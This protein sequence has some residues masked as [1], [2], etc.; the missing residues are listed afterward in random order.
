VFAAHLRVDRFDFRLRLR[1]RD[2]RR[3]ASDNPETPGVTRFHLVI[4]E[5]EWLP[6]FRAPAE[7]AATAEIEKLKGKIE[8]SGHHAYDGEIFSIEKKLRP[9]D[10]R[11]P[12]ETTLPQPRADDHNIVAAQG[13]FFG[14]KKSAFD[15]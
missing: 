11:I 9:D 13:A 7:T 12:I 1:R 15:R 8:I 14:L 10:L 6:N 5:G 3:Q 4:G 2:S